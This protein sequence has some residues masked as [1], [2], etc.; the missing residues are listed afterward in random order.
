[1][2]QDKK[3]LNKTKKALQENYGV[4]N[5]MKSKEIAKKTSDTRLNYSNTQKQ[6]YLN[7]RSETNKHRYGVEN[8]FEDTEKLKKIM[9]EKYGVENIA[10]VSEFQ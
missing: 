6:Q 4:D 8:P 2:L 5:P 10:Q 1:M 3:I 7:R 9:L